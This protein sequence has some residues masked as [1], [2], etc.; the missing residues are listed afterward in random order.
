MVE[1]ITNLLLV[2]YYLTNIEYT[3]STVIYREH[4]QII[5]E[6]LSTLSEHLGIIIIDLAVLHDNNVR[7]LNYLIKSKSR[8]Q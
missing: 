4:V 2:G 3:I 1:P 5:P 7:C 6:T 8:T